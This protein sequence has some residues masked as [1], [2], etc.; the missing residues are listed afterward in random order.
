[1]IVTARKVVVVVGLLHEVLVIVELLEDLVE[2]AELEH[3]VA[4]MRVVVG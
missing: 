4:D 1:M 3:K 2:E